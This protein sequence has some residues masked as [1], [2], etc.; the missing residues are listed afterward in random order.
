MHKITKDVPVNQ[1]IF[2]FQGKTVT[3][4]VQGNSGVI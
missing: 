3:S 2:Y 4:L 1:Q